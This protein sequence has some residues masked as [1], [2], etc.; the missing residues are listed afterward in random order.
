MGLLSQRLAQVVPH[1]EGREI[2]FDNLTVGNT[3]DAS[4]MLLHVGELG[5]GVYEEL[6]PEAGVVVQRGARLLEELNGA[7][8]KS[9]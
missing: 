7:G 6:N 3:A 5:S 1:G 2:G 8:E 9:V 4:Q